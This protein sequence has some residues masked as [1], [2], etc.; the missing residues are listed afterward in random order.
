MPTKSSRDTPLFA[1]A[2]R[3]YRLSDFPHESWVIENE[4]LR[5]LAS[6][7]RVSLISREAFGDFELTVE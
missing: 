5:A 4:T 6:G 1:K 7:P 3:G 2:W